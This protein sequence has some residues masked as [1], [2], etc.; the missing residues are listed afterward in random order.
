MSNATLVKKIAIAAALG[1]GMLLNVGCASLTSKTIGLDA[2]EIPKGQFVTGPG[3][4]DENGVM[5]PSPQAPPAELTKVTLPDYVIEPPDILLIEGIK[6]VPKTPVEIQSQDVLQIVVLG[7]VPERPIA[8]Q[9]LVD[10]GG[11]VDLGPG[12]GRVQLSGLTTSEAQEAIRQKLLAELQSVEVAVT[13]FQAAGQQLITGE[14]LVAPDGTVNLGLYGRVYVAGMSL[15]AARQAV[16]ERLSLYF[17]QPRVSVDVFV[18]NNKIYYIIVEGG[19]AGDRVIRIPCTGN[20]M[21]LDAIAQVGGIDQSSSKKMWIS[22]PTPGGSGCDQ[23]LP[24]DWDAI[25]RGADTSSN[26]QLLPGDRLFVAENRL[27]AW[28]TV[29]SIMLN[30]IER[31]IGFT[32]LGGQTIQT[33]QRF[34][35]GFQ[36]RAF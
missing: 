17:D 10:A 7:T 5:V 1:I 16:E 32:L 34:P 23:V 28:A 12:Y 2:Y 15:D 4:V 24:V 19:G 26:Y 25:T 27:I 11:G 33:L 18:Y 30:P 13:I 9:F 6:T 36:N 21:V 29:T 8:G 20:E 31:M 14:H 3:T 35:E 22:R